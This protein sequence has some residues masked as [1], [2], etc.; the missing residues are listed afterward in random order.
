MS[1]LLW[2]A[3][4]TNTSRNNKRKALEALMSVNNDLKTK[5]KTFEDKVRND[6]EVIE[7]FE[8]T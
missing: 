7:D 5:I 4:V 1:D 3:F 8:N 6:F 2:Y